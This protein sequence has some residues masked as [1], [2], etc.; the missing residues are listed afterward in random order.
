MLSTEKIR[1]AHR[2][3]CLLFAALLILLLTGVA[4]AAGTTNIQGSVHQPDGTNAIGTITIS[5]PAFTTPSNEQV[6][7]G[8]LTTTIGADGHVAIDLISNA[9]APTGMLYTADY[10]LKDGSSRREHWLVPARPQV[11][12]AEVRAEQA[13]S[14]PVSAQKGQPQTPPAD[15]QQRSGTID[16]HTDIQKYGF[17]GDKPRSQAPPLTHYSDTTP[18]H[19]AD[20]FHDPARNSFSNAN[21]SWLQVCNYTSQQGWTGGATGW[22]GAK[23]NCMNQFKFSSVPGID[24][25]TPKVGPGGWSE[26]SGISIRSVVNSPGISSILTSS[27]VK[28]GIGDNV[29]FY[30][31][32]FNY[33]GAV[34]GSDE[35]NHVTAAAGGEQSTVY[36]GYVTLGRTG[37]TSLQVHCITDC[38]FPGDGRYLI[39]TQRPVA[40]GY[41]TGKTNPSGAFTPGT[42]TVD[43]TVTPSTA[44]GT[45]AADVV[46]PVA[47]QI[48]T[49]YTNMTFRVNVS[50]GQFAPGSLVCFGGQYHEQAI[51]ST[52]SGT[53][54]VSLT[55]PLRHAHESGSWIM[56]GGPCG[57]F[58]EFA[59]NSVTVDKQ[60]IRYPI[61]ILGATDSHTIVY[62]YFAFSIGTFRGG[63]WPGNVTFLRLPAA[64][65]NNH[66][67]LVTMTPG[68][69]NQ[70]QHPELYNAAS[71]YISNAADPRFNGICTNTK[72]TTTG[73]LSCSQGSSTGA[74]SASAEVS[75]GTS[76]SGNSAFNL[77]SGAEVLDVLDHSIS[78]PAVNGT[79]TLEPNSAAWTV[80]DSVEN[81]HHYAAA[82][83]SERRTLIINN[84]M[85]LSGWSRALAL[86]GQGIS[87]GNPADPSSYSADKISNLEP[88]TTYAYHGGTVTPPGGIYLGG[89]RNSGLFNYGLAM[90]YAPDPPGSSAFYI[91]CPASGCSDSA[92]YYDFFKLV[93]NGG[94]ST[95][96]YTPATNILSLNGKG[97]NLKNEPLIASTMQSETNGGPASLKFSAIDTSEQ[98]HTWTLNAPPTGGGFTIDLPQGNGTLALS[99]A[100][101]ASGP[102]HSAG[103]VP[104]PGPNPGATRFLREDGKWVAICRQEDTDI[105]LPLRPAV[106]R[107]ASGQDD[108]PIP[109]QPKFPAVVAHAARDAQT[110]AVNYII[111]YS[112]DRGGTFRLT[113]SV[114]IE[115]PCVSGTLSVNAYLSPVVGH[116]VGQ[117]QKPD[118]MT[119]YTNTTSA[120][121]AHAAA[122]IPVIASVGFNGVKTGSLRY[123]VDAVLEQLQ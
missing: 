89:A 39:D 113:I 1:I 38:E 45:L 92:F 35:G 2:P 106:L 32:N 63:Y 62:R 17:K 27:Q 79:F 49:G 118:C 80:N 22:T 61:D 123:M 73:Q 101:G 29:G 93:G 108:K 83:D 7:A 8:N 75:F 10:H 3:V 16:M 25:G 103:M 13:P 99:N 107:M 28:A 111:N 116:S 76:A 110:T 6:P 87:G 117:T 81:V 15:D 47:A 122:G 86:A 11:T 44:W 114:F 36:T 5:W 100:F 20:F 42:F 30:F 50:R 40:T 58:I 71:V 34:A 48:G 104:D 57:T 37:A 46:T 109:D 78:P 21:D 18:D 119:A 120:I 102:I 98:T 64:H 65:L 9:G 31:Y 19:R 41:V 96:T 66:D 23:N 105:A 74:T 26:D 52:V 97:L 51:V 60:K 59:A 54:P 121:T 77:W 55:V 67:G 69:G 4:R 84:P 72:I 90:M 94:V 56:Q 12:L 33:G 14:A 70:V 53:S 112:P 68:G 88:A 115:S 43:A 85:R 95:F 91:G 24:L 82:M